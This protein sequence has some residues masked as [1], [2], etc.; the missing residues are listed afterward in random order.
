V[1]R[2][3]PPRAAPRDPRGAA[4]AGALVPDAADVAERALGAGAVAAR[5]AGLKLLGAAASADE[6]AFV[7]GPRPAPPR[8][9]ARRRARHWALRGAGGAR[10]AVFVTSGQTRSG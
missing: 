8:P 10:R 1:T 2:P 3:A 6:E 4:Q 7:R 9:A 5:L